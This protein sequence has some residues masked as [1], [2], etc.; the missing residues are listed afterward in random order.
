M[1]FFFKIWNF[2]G[3]LQGSLVLGLPPRWQYMRMIW[4]EFA[5]VEM[6]TIAHT[7]AGRGWKVGR[8]M[9]RSAG[10]KKRKALGLLSL[11]KWHRGCWQQAD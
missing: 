11:D 5:M 7:L 8:E 10:K 9:G 4:S 1:V 6:T 2:G 3:L